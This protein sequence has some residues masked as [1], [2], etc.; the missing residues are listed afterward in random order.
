MF[1]NQI[2][3]FSRAFGN[4]ISCWIALLVASRAAIADPTPT[5]T[6]LSPANSPPARS[7]LAITYDP[8]SGKII[9][10]GG[11]DGRRHINDTLAFDGTTSTHLRTHGCPPARAAAELA[12][13][14]VTQKVVLVC[15]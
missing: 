5:W 1:L 8:V 3:L 12:Y 11:F 4:G 14:A 13:D 6:Q 2:R 7:Y 15:G 9:M 10:F